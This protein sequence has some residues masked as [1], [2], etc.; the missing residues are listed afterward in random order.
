MI[1]R[2]YTLALLAWL[3]ACPAATAQQLP[4][5][6]VL[7]REKLQA[8]VQKLERDNSDLARAAAI[9]TP[10]LTALIAAGGLLLTARKAVADREAQRKADRQA[11]AAAETTR[12]DERFA[13]AAQGI[14]SDNPASKRAAAVVVTSMVRERRAD[15]S[16]QAMNLLLANLQVDHDDVTT[17]LLV[18]ALERAVRAAPRRLLQED[19][20]GRVMSLS[21]VIGPALNLASLDARGIDLAYGKFPGADMRRCILSNSKGYEA[22]IEDAE[23][24]RSD[25]TGVEWVHAHLR[26][27]HFQLARLTG[28][29][30]TNTDMVGCDFY[31][32]DLSGANLFESNLRGAKFH[33]AKLSGANFLRARLDEKSLE[34][35]VRAEDW[36]GAKFDTEAA[37]QL[38]ALG[39]ADNS[40]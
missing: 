40:E 5:K 6:D 17:R 14:A 9:G 22:Y 38:A 11:R 19:E 36:K 16:D 21:H 4:S 33:R 34:S 7:E 18:K 29:K 1:L 24:D 23:F 3:L 30:L 15:L 28:A 8:E 25:L 39:P 37:E 10:L 20:A 12:F 31:Q 27:S 32:A 13:S 26:G 2:L 35:I